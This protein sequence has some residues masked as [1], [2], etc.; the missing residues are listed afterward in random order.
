MNKKFFKPFLLSLGVIS[1]LSTSVLA[2][3]YT[4]TESALTSME[5]SS[6]VENIIEDELD[7]SSFV[8]EATLNYLIEALTAYAEANPDLSFDELDIYVKD[9]TKSLAEIN[10]LGIYYPSPIA[11]NPDERVLYNESPSKGLTAMKC[12]AT[13]TNATVDEYGINGHND[14]SDAFRHA[15]WNA[16]MVKN[17]DFSFA[18]RWATAHETGASDQAT[19]E[20]S[21]DMFNNS[22]GREVYGSSGSTTDSGLR[23]TTRAWVKSGKM[24]K[25]SGS[26]LV[27]TD[28]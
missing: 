14:D 2:S 26:S 11:L 28:K 27:P 7:Y 19:I 6:L 10:P 22:K 20:Y 3:D 9:L 5:E 23:N 13:A 21:M 4:D 12:G 25:I 1:M 18:K 8:T 17:I 24:R 15:Y 16:L